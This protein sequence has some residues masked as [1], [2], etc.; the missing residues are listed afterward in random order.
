MFTAAQKRAG[1]DLG[2]DIGVSEAAHQLDVDTQTIEAWMRW[3]PA[4]TP[5]GEKAAAEPPAP[6]DDP[7]DIPAGDPPRAALAAVPT[8]WGACS[9]GERF[10]S[11]EEWGRHNGQITERATGTADIAAHRL[12]VHY[13]IPR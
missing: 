7:D 8:P 12:T 10:D 5:A 2:R 6:D 11:R 4:A 13:G 3:F 1:A 9:C